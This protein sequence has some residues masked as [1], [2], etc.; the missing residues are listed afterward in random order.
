MGRCI[1]GKKWK[2]EALTLLGKMECGS[3]CKINLRIWG[4][5]TA[6]TDRALGLE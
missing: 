3:L 5:G 4:A 6:G 2:G 1:L